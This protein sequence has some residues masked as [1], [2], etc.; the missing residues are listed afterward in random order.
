M[1]RKIWCDEWKRKYFGLGG[2]SE[3]GPRLSMSPYVPVPSAG[4]CV[5]EV[6]KIAIC[7]YLSRCC[8]HG[9]DDDT[10]SAWRCPWRQSTSRREIE[11]DIA[12]A[13]GR[14]LS[15]EI[16]GSYD[17]RN[18]PRVKPSSKTERGL[19][20]STTWLYIG[21]LFRCRIGTPEWILCALNVHCSNSFIFGK[22]CS[23]FD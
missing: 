19:A 23:N 6:R 5:Q 15:A 7:S 3:Q 18:C 22:N 21:P 13:I 11:R 2:E 10:S 14:L 4:V 9:G 1:R 8:C 16:Q 20:S 17:Q 12:I